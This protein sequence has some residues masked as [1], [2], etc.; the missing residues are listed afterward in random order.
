[1]AKRIKKIFISFLKT[2]KVPD[3]FLSL[4]E[5]EFEFKK[6]AKKISGEVRMPSPPV[7]ELCMG[8]AHS[9]PSDRGHL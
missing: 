5:E 9:P 1:M 8:L 6:I 2:K 4:K 7:R 3:A